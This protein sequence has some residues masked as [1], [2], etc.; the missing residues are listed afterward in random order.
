MIMTQEHCKCG[1][2]SVEAILVFSFC[3]VLRVI[4]LDHDRQGGVSMQSET[5]EKNN[6]KMRDM[7][8]NKMHYHVGIV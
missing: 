3:S 6:Q 4:K 5:R 1:E 8:L 2:K 7:D